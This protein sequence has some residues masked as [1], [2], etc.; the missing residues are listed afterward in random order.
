MEK[1][2]VIELK[3]V[4]FYSSLSRET[5]CFQCDILVNGVKSF[6]ADNDGHGGNTCISNYVKCQ[7]SYKEID[8]YFKSLPKKK[9][10][11]FEYEQTFESAVDDLFNDW[12]I[13]ND[14]KKLNKKI[15]KLMF[16]NIV[17]QTT[18]KEDLRCLFWKDNTKKNV[19]IEKLLSIPKFNK[20][21]MD[22]VEE[23]KSQ[24]YIILNTNIPNI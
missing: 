23:L 12:L 20:I 18:N 4:K 5:Y 21:V 9:F 17:Y 3:N 16:D 24:G 15:D 13:E 2:F 8:N 22:K 10:Q 19:A 6:Y 1:K 14:K 11:D 7:F